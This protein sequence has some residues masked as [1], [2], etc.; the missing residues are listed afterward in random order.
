LT[1]GGVRFASP[2]IYI[3]IPPLVKIEAGLRM[4]IH[5]LGLEI[6]LH[7]PII[8]NN[9]STDN[10]HVITS[11]QILPQL[12]YPS[13]RTGRAG[14]L[15]KCCLA[16][17]RSFHLQWRTDIMSHAVENLGGA[18]ICKPVSIP[19]RSRQDYLFLS[20]SRASLW[21]I[22]TSTVGSLVDFVQASI[23]QLEQDSRG[24]P[25]WKGRSAKT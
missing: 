17:S 10:P 15:R 13:P 23:V 22:A 14:F 12:R 19:T 24:V 7:T 3:Q 20:R 9:D 2:N 11:H 18:R 5:P 6:V 8:S 16:S 1:S 25:N 4:R 21:T